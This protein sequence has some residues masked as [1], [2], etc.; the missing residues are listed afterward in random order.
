LAPPPLTD[1]ESAFLAHL[2][3]IEEVLRFI[4]RRNHCRPEEAE[5]FAAMARLKLIEDDYAVLRKFGGRSSVRTYLVT[6]L[7]RLFLDQ[8]IQRWGKWRPSMAARKA[9]ET[10]VRLE[11]LVSRD[12]HS[13]D[14]AWQILTTNEGRSISRGEVTAIL[15]WLPS[16]LPRRASA[17]E[18]ASTLVVS[19][20]VVEN[21]TVAREAAPR[22]RQ[23]GKA[24]RAA[25]LALSPEDRLI[26]RMRFEDGATVGAISRTLRLEE[27]PLYRRLE[28]ILDRLRREMEGRGITLEDIEDLVDSDGVGWIA[29]VFADRPG[30]SSPLAV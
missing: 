12:G 3:L 10:A 20:E 26:V 16:R 30:N 8:R 27:K 6:V 5:E 24:L 29:G 21:P 15:S 9:G 14:E 13:P 4:A 11:T 22:A 23:V 17:E 19:A 2:P 7:H 18:G 1:P 28:R 25:L